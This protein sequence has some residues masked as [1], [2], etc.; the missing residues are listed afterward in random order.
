[1]L[2]WGGRLELRNNFYTHQQ[3]CAISPESY[4]R[5]PLPLWGKKSRWSDKDILRYLLT[6]SEGECILYS[7]A[8]F[9]TDELD[10]LANK[11]DFGFWILDLFRVLIIL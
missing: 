9:I 2:T 6:V 3:D 7:S 8:P 4:A 11:L 1:M 5:P 10:D